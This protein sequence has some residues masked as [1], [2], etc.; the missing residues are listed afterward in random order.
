MRSVARNIETLRV[1]I[2]TTCYCYYEARFP[3]CERG[4]KEGWIVY[5]DLKKLQTSSFELPTAALLL[6]LYLNIAAIKEIHSS[7]RT[8]LLHYNSNAA[9]MQ[10]TMKDVLYLKVL[11]RCGFV[12]VIVQKAK[13]P[14][15]EIPNTSFDG[16]NLRIS[17]VKTSNSSKPNKTRS[18]TSNTTNPDL[19]KLQTQLSAQSFELED[20][21]SELAEKVLALDNIQKSLRSLADTIEDFDSQ[22]LNILSSMKFN[23]AT[24]AQPSA[25]KSKNAPRSQFLLLSVTKELVRCK[26]QEANLTVRLWTNDLD[27]FVGISNARCMCL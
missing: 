26:L 22:N 12:L 5:P 7:F 1:A 27:N 13:N 18:E 8:Q 6:L 16:T 14:T 4:F 23:E 2:Q 19:I 24:S 21:R 10:N 20:A 17:E 3:D 11:N 25:S 9:H 15:Q